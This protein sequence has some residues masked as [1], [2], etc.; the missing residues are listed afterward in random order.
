MYIAKR[1]YVNKEMSK[2]TFQTDQ[3]L[4]NSMGDKSINHALLAF[5]PS[6]RH[7]LNDPLFREFT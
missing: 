3:L 4:E 7:G 2:Y 5:D 1:K 6:L